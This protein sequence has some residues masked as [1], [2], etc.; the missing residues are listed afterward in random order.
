MPS[1]PAGGE[2]RDLPPGAALARLRRSRGITGQH[3]GQLTGMSQA[4]ISRIETGSAIP[5][6][7]DVYILCQAMGADEAWTRDVMEKVEEARTAVRD[8]RV[9]GGI[10]PDLGSLE[11]ASSEVRIFQSTTI[12]SLLQTSEYARA[13]LNLY[14]AQTGSSFVDS[15][16][17]V[18]AR[19]GRQVV[20]DDPAKQ[21]I[22]I[23]QE[24]VLQH[25]VCHPL[26]MAAQIERIK[27]IGKRSNVLMMIIP[28]FARLEI[29][30]VHGF[31]ILDDRV[32]IID[33]L[34]TELTAMG[35]SDLRL[36]REAFNRLAQTA[37]INVDEI[38]SHYYDFYLKPHA[39][40]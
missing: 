27:E 17:I 39:A 23:M 35:E 19:I 6:A 36:Y 21:F 26:H 10:T 33:L 16:R 9:S 22:F 3:L 24:A 2:L 5:S 38:L 34:N 11:A 20:L 7:R 15:S 30:P 29:P 4:K 31:T 25:M 14:T 37:T 40:G 18:S 12:C 32:L 8:V 13:T 1:S 28:R